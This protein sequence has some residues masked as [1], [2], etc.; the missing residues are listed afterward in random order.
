MRTLLMILTGAVVILA[1]AV[2]ATDAANL[3]VSRS[4]FVFSAVDTADS[5]FVENDGTGSLSWSI[6][7][8]ESWLEAAP[9]SGVNSA[10][11]QTIVRVSVDRTG[12]A[13]GI[14]SGDLIVSSNGGNKTL[15]VRMTVQNAPKLDGWGDDVTL[16][17]ADTYYQIWIRNAGIAP[18]EGSVI[19]DEPWIDVAPPEFSGLSYGERQIIR[20]DLDAGSLPSP[21]EEHTGH[22]MIDSNGG[23]DVVTVRYLPSPLSPGMLGIYADNMGTNCN[24]VATTPS[25]KTVYV[26]HT[27]TDGA[28]A[29]QFSAPKPQCWTNAMYLSDSDM[30]PVTIGNSQTGKS[31]GYGTCRVGTI[32]VLPINY[33][34]QGPPT[35]FC[36]PYP[37]LPDP[38]APSGRIE[39]ADC[40]FHTV[41][42]YGAT[43]IVNPNASCPCESPPVGVEETTWGRVK[44]L[45]APK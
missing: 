34:V 32:N 43:A 13:D 6:T 40:E 15:L 9:L 17:P 44:S 38:I 12:L 2:V 23:S 29:C 42:A 39:I 30:F 8:T 26:V 3:Y 41:Y 1:F 27:R 28:T 11:Q 33:F 35:Q 20:I 25:V 21:G 24:I 31:V 37:V 14:Y 19:S 16:T 18:L 7:M 4:S 36:C 45:Y 10:G 22:V 5:F